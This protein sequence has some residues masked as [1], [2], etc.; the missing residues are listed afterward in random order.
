[1]KQNYTPR[2]L[3]IMRFIV[4]YRKTHDCSPTLEE[5]GNALG[6][7]RV[8]VHQHIGALEKRG[9]IARGNSYR[10]NIQ[11]VDPDITGENSMDGKLFE[12]LKTHA[13]HEPILI[14]RYG[15]SPEGE[16]DEIRLECKQC[17]VEF[18]T[19]KKEDAE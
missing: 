7:H 3:E 9:A 14:R 18:Y 16:P 11:V 10:R 15:I 19:I 4:D 17:E 12:L 2:Q 6:I 5:I 1:V 13:R 8:T